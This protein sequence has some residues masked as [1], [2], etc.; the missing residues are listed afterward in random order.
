MSF[1]LSPVRSLSGEFQRLQ[2]TGLEHA[3]TVLRGSDQDVKSA[4]T[5]RA[6][7]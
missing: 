3:V 1:E 7:S 5:R 6:G 4:F 2:R